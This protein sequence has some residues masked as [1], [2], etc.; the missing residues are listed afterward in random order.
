[1]EKG[2]VSENVTN[3]GRVNGIQEHDQELWRARVCMRAYMQDGARAC[4]RACACVQAWAPPSRR[5]SSSRGRH[6]PSPP[7][8][9]AS[10]CC[11]ALA[12][13]LAHEVTGSKK[14]E[15]LAPTTRKSVSS[16]G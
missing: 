4:V 13:P 11:L 6:G 12:M 15:S 9:C 14:F 8:T 7:P 16:W 5:G 10:T 1:M 3:S 2:G